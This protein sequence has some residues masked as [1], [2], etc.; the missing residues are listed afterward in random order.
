MKSLNTKIAFAFITSLS[1]LALTSAVSSANSNGRVTAPAPTPSCNGTVALYIGNS[2]LTPRTCFW[3]QNTEAP[4]GHSYTLNR[5]VSKYS[6]SGALISAKLYKT[7]VSPVAAPINGFDQFGI[8]PSRVQV[9][10]VAHGADSQ[11]ITLSDENG[12]TFPRLR[13]QPVYGGSV[14]PTAI[15]DLNVAR[16]GK[17]LVVTGSVAALCPACQRSVVLKR[18]FVRHGKRISAVGS[19][20]SSNSVTAKNGV[21]HFRLK[22]SSTHRAGLFYGVITIPRSFPLSDGLGNSVTVQ[23]VASATNVLL[24]LHESANGRL[25]QHRTYTVKPSLQVAR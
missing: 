24:T 13:F 4:A 20:I 5:F 25:T 7:P 1:L 14:S 11:V 18:A 3:S 2:A 22:V 8:L 12:N 10:P 17:S 19:V 6:D 16:T 23:G 15:S 21:L 9:A